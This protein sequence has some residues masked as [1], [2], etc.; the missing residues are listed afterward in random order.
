MRGTDRYKQFRILPARCG[1]L[2]VVL[3][4][5]PAKDLFALS[6]ADVLH[7]ENGQGYQ[8][9]F[10]PRHAREFRSYIEQAGATT[11]PLTFNLRGEEG[12]GWRLSRGSGA[13]T[14]KLWIRVPSGN[15]RSVLAQVDCQHR[16]GMM[17][18]CDIP[19]A[20]QCFLGLSK[21]EEMSIFSVINAQAKGLSSSL[22]DFHTT[23]LVSDLEYT[24]VDL[25]IA[26]HLNDDRESPWYGK[27][28]LGGVATQGNVRRISLR[29]LQSATKQLLQRCPVL[30]DPSYTPMQKYEMVR[31]F[32]RAA[33]AIWPKAWL[34][35]R[36]YLLLKGV[37]VTAVSLLAAD[38]ITVALSKERTLNAETFREFLSPLA[39]IDWSNTG[40]FKGFGGRH[41]ANEVRHDLFTKLFPPRIAKLQAN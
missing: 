12:D 1:Q 38:I 13:G 19:L 24:Q 34:T 20:F 5:A 17:S 27:V 7:E 11:I 8:R 21:W 26:K 29:G 25:F 23:K 16:L 3:G 14:S 35:P 39:A 40:P 10:D 37:G 28:K 32:W 15:R 9:P 30:S 6:F 33:A 31:E 18:D 4:A 36:R 2:R 22:L 41:G